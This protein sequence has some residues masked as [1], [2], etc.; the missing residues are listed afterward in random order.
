MQAITGI[1]SEPAQ[2]FNL[3]PGDGS[4]ATL[5]IA[6]RPQQLGWFYDLVWNGT[7]PSTDINGRRI[8]NFP[9]LLRQFENLL[10]FG[11]ACI[12]QD[13]YEPLGQNDFQSGYATLLLLTKADIAA[14]N[15]AIF[16]GE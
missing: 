5:T 16:P 9:N 13:G 3:T 12:T 14:I 8:T 7:T 15:A 4:T 2:V 6:Y 10:S 1:T 11:V